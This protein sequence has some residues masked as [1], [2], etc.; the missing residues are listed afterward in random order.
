MLDVHGSRLKGAL[1]S[2]PGLRLQRRS[3][4][5]LPETHIDAKLK[6]VLE[7]RA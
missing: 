7:R 6:G 5:L 1:E 3:Q 4:G 2:A